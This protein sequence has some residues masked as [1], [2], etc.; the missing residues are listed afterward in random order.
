MYPGKI[1]PARIALRRDRIAAVLGAPV[2]DAIVHQIFE[3]LELKP[4]QTAQGWTVEVPTFRADLSGEEDLLE[5]I[6]RHYGFDKFPGTLPSSR[7]FGALL[8]QENKVRQVRKVL[9]ASGY[10]EIYTYSFSNEEMERRFYPDI[11]PVRL[12]NPLSEEAT[13]L[14]TSLIPGMLTTLQWNINRGTRNL[15]LYE[16]S[17][18]YWNGGERRSLLL[19]A[20]GNVTP[21]NVHQSCAGVRFF[22]AEGGCR[23]ASA[24]IQYSHEADDGQHSEVLPSGTI[25]SRRPSGDVRGTPSFVCRAFQVPATRLSGGDRY[26]SYC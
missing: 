26:S 4:A 13:I 6:A 18:V 10:S 23:R 1:K 7:N 5:E 12:R 3:R 15:Q 9:S 16:L 11:E 2:E 25:R 24:R 8:P 17:K 20:C 21:G 19:G 22:C 14:R